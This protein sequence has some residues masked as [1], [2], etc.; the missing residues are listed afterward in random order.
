MMRR[1]NKMAKYSQPHIAQLFVSEVPKHLTILQYRYRVTIK[2]P[3]KKRNSVS[4]KLSFMKSA[5]TNVIEVLDD[6]EKV[7]V[8][9]YLNDIW[10]G[11]YILRHYKKDAKVAYDQTRIKS[12]TAQNSESPN[13]IK[14][15]YLKSPSD[16]GYIILMSFEIIDTFLNRL[17]KNKP[18]AQEY[19]IFRTNNSHIDALQSG[20]LNEKLRPGQVVIL[21][22]STITST[23]PK[24]KAMKDLAFRVE[25]ELARHRKDPRFDERFH[26]IHNELLISIIEEENIS[27]EGVISEAEYKRSLAEASIK[28]D[29]NGCVIGEINVNGYELPSVNIGYETTNAFLLTAEQIENYEKKSNA[30]I[31]LQKEAHLETMNRY[32]RLAELAEQYQKNRRVNLATNFA[33]TQRFVAANKYSLDALGKSLQSKFLAY[34]VRKDYAR[35]A[36][37]LVSG[38]GVIGVV[39]ERLY[40]YEKMIKQTTGLST[41]LRWGGRIMLMWTVVEAGKTVAAATKKN[42]HIYTRKV[43]FIETAKAEAALVGGVF[44]AGVGRGLLTF[45][46]IL[47]QAKAGQVIMTIGGL[48]GAAGSSMFVDKAL[49]QSMGLCK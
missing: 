46:S 3:D 40:V 7:Q 13:H 29:N 33:E 42:N 15:V 5:K 36:N 14:E 10:M 20:N 23:N 32:N 11:G 27:V 35:F 44:G 1:Q 41:T 8:D 48:A 26:A 21:S 12:T 30:T 16:C 43:I 45:L 25:Q 49:Y 9:V 28:Y 34:E 6:Q 24:L 17:Y 2:S 37:M 19:Q 31:R 4:Q 18:T 47:P 39:N 22:H 38:N